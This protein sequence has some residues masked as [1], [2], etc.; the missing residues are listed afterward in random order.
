MPTPTP[1]SLVEPFAVNAGGSFITNPIPVDSQISVTP[2]A[3]SFEDGFPPLCSTKKT[4]GGIPPSGA[5]MNGILYMI[6]AHTAWVAAGGAYEYN[7]DVITVVGGYAAGAI[8]RSAT[9]PTKFF[10]CLDD[11]TTTDPD[12]DETGWQAF[13]PLSL[14]IGLETHAPTAG[15]HNDFE[16]SS[17]SGF[18]EI[19]T[20]AG[21]VT[22]TGILPLDSDGGAS[23]WPGMSVTFS[24]TGPNLLTLAA[25]GLGSGAD[26]RIRAS[27][28]LSVIQDDS[29]T[30]RYSPTGKWVRS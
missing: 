15:T 3:A 5:D 24:C 10:Y 17:S 2:G 6:S 22:L 21:A 30:L 8:V 28:D 12:I 27:T 18:V 9:I 13:S 20:T 16:I 7:A 1:P 19:D 11:D 14:S 29:I 23:Y 25:N 4:S 26:N